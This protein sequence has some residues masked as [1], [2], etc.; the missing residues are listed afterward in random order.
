MLSESYHVSQASNSNQKLLCFLKID[1]LSPIHTHGKEVPTLVLLLF[2]PVA[3]DGT[4]CHKSFAVNTGY[5][6]SGAV[7]NTCATYIMVY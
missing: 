6:A 4:G 5:D 1:T 3:L 7:S 2:S